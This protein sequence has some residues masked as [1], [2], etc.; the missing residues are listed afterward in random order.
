MPVD[1]AAGLT[2]RAS[3]YIYPSLSLAGLRRRTSVKRISRRHFAKLQI[4]NRSSQ[5]I[6]S[7]I[8]N[9]DQEE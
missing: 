9:Q 2:E 5:F 4:A 1:P 7:Q 8:M 6:N 3:I